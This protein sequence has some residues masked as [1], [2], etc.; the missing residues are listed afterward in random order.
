MHRPSR[1]GRTRLPHRGEI[2]VLVGD[3]IRPK[4]LYKLMMRR[5][6]HPKDVQDLIW[7]HIQHGNLDLDPRGLLVSG[8]APASPV[9]D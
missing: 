3:G 2:L 7:Y 9:E 4:N 6:I 8:V 1:T 5:G